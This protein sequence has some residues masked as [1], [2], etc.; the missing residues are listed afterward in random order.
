MTENQSAAFYR[1]EGT[2]VGRPTLATAAYLAANT[3]G[4]AQRIGRLGNVAVA[5]PFA[6]AGGLVTGS[7]GSRITWMGIRGMSEDRLAVLSEE[8]YRDYVEPDLL[9]VGLDLIKAS[10]RRGQRLVLISD[11]IDWVMKP[12]AE[13]LGADDLICNRLEVKRGEATGRLCDPVIGGGLAGQWARSFADKHEIDLE[14]SCAYGARGS[15]SLLLS[16]IGQPCA[17]NPDRQLRRLADDHD[18]PVVER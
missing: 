15:D 3:Q 12:L 18:W 4:L 1:I 2:L 13:R 6:F 5:A 7:A 11:N 16:A 8:Y 17:V 9:A 10:R 14:A